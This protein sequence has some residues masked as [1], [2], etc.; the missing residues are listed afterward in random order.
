M[1]KLFVFSVLAL[2]LCAKENIPKDGVVSVNGTWISQTEIDKVV[3]MYRQQMMQMMPQQALQPVPPEVKKNIAMQLIANELALQEAKKRH[4]GYD[5]TKLEA[6]YAGIIK[7]FPDAATMKAELGRMGQT[8][9]TLRGQIK[10]GL[11]VDS[12]MKTLFK[13]SDT[14]TSADCKAYYDG[15]QPQFASEKRVKASQILFL[16]KKEMTAEQ[17]NAVADKAKKVLAELRGGKDFAACAKKYS[18]D[19]NASAGGDI[20]W[21]KKGDI[22]PEFER[23]AITLKLDEISDV[24][25]TDVGL[26]IIKKTAEENMPPKTFD[27]VKGQIKNMLELK[28]HNDEVKMF[29]DSLM[30]ISKIT[31]ADTSY[32]LAGMPGRK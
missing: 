23:V 26:H 29:V 7:Q 3:E 25:Q 9:Q 17:K 4:I 6:T 14:A 30:A 11:T 22:K 13:K 24:F 5:S 1:K 10:D 19:P 8:E 15:N 28:K 32:K 21:F 18:Q 20:G 2:L 16:I 31:F 12:L 27:E